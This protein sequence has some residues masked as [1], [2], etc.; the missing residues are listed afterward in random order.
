M[1]Q[2][3]AISAG[4][5]DVPVLHDASLAIA[6]GEIVALVGRN[7]VGKTTLARVIAGL[8]SPKQGRILFDDADVTALDASGR[9][10][11]GIGYVPQGRGIFGRLSVAENLTMGRDIGNRGESAVETGFK[12]FPILEKRRNQRASTLSGGEQQ[13]LSIARVLCGAP[14]LL[15]LDEPSDGVQPTIVE[16]IAEAVTSATADRSLTTLLIEQ[17]IDLIS[18]MATQ[19]FVMEKGQIVD[20]LGIEDMRK[21]ENIRKYLAI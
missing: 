5:G 6:R 15:L 14:G 10:R 2:L 17:N 3:E 4:Y 21:T 18:M 12:L 1:L 7:G 8:I 11:R 16:E 19:C 9:A 20:R 13:M